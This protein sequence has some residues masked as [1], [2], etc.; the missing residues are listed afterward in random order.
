MPARTVAQLATEGIM[1]VDDLSEFESEDFAQ[2]A[3]NLCKPPSIPD[4]ANP[5]QLLRQ[6]P[7]VLGAKSLKR[8]KVA[9][10]AVCYYDMIGRP[11]TVNMMHYTN[12]LRNFEQQWK[13]LEERKKEDAPSVP[14]IT[15]NLKVTKWS[16]SFCDFLSKVIGKRYAPLS[17]M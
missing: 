17:L 9:A 12:T 10:N 4:P 16:E 13:A 3:D 11:L 14:K 5:G 1:T 6:E 15:R 7:F 2:I 8:L